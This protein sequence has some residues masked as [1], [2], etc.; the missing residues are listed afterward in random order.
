MVQIARA[1]LPRHVARRVH[2]GPAEKVHAALRAPSGKLRGRREEI[3]QVPGQR[4][5]AERRA[6]GRRRHVSI[7]A[8]QCC[9][10]S[11]SFRTTMLMCAPQTLH[12][13][14]NSVL[15]TRKPR[16]G[17]VIFHEMEETKKTQ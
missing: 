16:S 10:W 15:F 4:I 2:P 7:R 1:I 14:P 9:M 13:H 8:R 11:N 3:A 5:L 12:V 6:V 17:W